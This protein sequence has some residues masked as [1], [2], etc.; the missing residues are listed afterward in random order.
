MASRSIARHT[1]A[2]AAA[3]AFLALS[4]GALNAVD[5]SD[6]L[7][8]CLVNDGGVFEGDLFTQPGGCCT[9]APVVCRKI[10]LDR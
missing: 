10:D 3:V 6:N 8:P 4:C 1:L 9:S 5:L 7:P 2:F